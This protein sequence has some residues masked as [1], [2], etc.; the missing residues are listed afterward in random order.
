[1]LTNLAAYF[2]VEQ[3]IGSWQHYPQCPN[4]RPMLPVEELVACAKTNA[5]R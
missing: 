3:E 2:Y 1:V 5:T 4:K